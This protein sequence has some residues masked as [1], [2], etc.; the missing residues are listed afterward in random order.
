MQIS[1]EAP[2]GGIDTG[3]VLG[4]VGG[5]GLILLAVYRGGDVD[6]FMNLNALLIVLGGMVSTAF[7]AFSSR[8]ILSMVPVIINAFRPDVSNQS[9]I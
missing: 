6:V 3:T 1:K 7:I 4:V 5:V 8:K 9:I 2:E